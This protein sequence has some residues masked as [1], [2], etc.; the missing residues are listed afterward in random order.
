[1]LECFQ[2]TVI[3]GNSGSGKSVFAESLAALTHI[4]AIDLDSL[5]WERDGQKRDEE[6]AKRLVRDAAAAPSWIIEGVFGW[7]AE[8]AMPKATA[9][10]WLDLP[11]SVCREGLLVRGQR[12]GAE[13]DFAD[14]FAWSKAYWDR[15]TSSSFKGHSHLFESFPGTK[16]RLRDRGEV[17]QL[18]TRLV[19]S[20]NAPN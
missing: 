11:W 15:E 9:L 2:R 7:L 18:L 4:A 10:I 16:L 6:T 14:L 20:T 17:R 12:G 13:A 8:I 19:A 3:I 5:H 1:M